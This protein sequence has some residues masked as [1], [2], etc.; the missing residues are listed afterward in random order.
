MIFRVL[1]LLGCG[2]H[3]KFVHE[4]QVDTINELQVDTIN[5]LQV[6]TKSE[7]SI[8][9]TRINVPVFK[10]GK[11][12][13]LFK[14]ELLAWKEV[15]DLVATKQ[16]I[17]VALLLPEDDSLALRAKLFDKY[18]VEDLKKDNGLDT[19][20]AFLD[21]HLG[22]D[23]LAD[24][25]V[26]YSQFEDY[27]QTSETTAD[28]IGK[29]E[30]LYNRLEKKGT[31]LPEEIKSYKLLRSA[32]LSQDER[33]LVL[34]GIDYTKKDTMFEQAKLSLKKFKGDG[35]GVSGISIDSSNVAIKVEPAFYS[36]GMQHNTTRTYT[37]PHE[38]DTAYYM[39]GSSRGW[40][41]SQ[42]SQQARGSA[43]GYPS[44]GQYF[45]GQRGSRPGRG[46][47]GFRPQPGRSDRSTWRGGSSGAGFQKSTNPTGDDGKPLRCACCDSIRHFLRDCPHSWENAKQSA[48]MVQAECYDQE[49][50][51]SEQFEAMSCGEPSQEYSAFHT[52]V[53]YTG[54]DVHECLQLHQESHASAIVD[55]ACT[56]NVCGSRWLA[57]Y[58]DTLDEDLKAQVSVVPSSKIFR[59]GIGSA[60]SSGEYELPVFLAGQSIML[61]TD[62]VES[63]VPL[64]LSKQCMKDLGFSLDL[65]NDSATVMGKVVPLNST[66]S[67]HY[68]L[69]LTR[70]GNDVSAF[71]VDLK[72]VHGGDL[73]K[74]LTHVHRQM[75]HPSEQKLVDLFKK[76]GAW[77]TEYK[78]VLDRIYEGCDTCKQFAR[79]PSNP[80]VALPRAGEFNQIVAMDLKQWHGFWILH[81]VDM[82]TRYTISVFVP[83]K[84]STSII[85]AIMCHWVAYFGVMEKVFTD[86]GGEFKNDEMREV[87]SVLNF[88]LSSS[89]ADSPFQ[90]GLCEKNHGVVDLILTKLSEDHP[91]VKKEVLLR[92]A[93]MSKN[94]LQMWSGYSSNQLVFGTNPRLPT[95]LCSSLPG[96][97][98]STVSEALARHLCVLHDAR[99][100]FI[101]SECDERL[102]RALR[103]RIR[104]SETVYQRGDKVFYK[105]EGRQQWLGPATV[106]FQD[107]KIVLLDHG[108]YFI[109][110][111]PNRLIHSKDTNP[112]AEK[113]VGSG[114]DDASIDCDVE[115]DAVRLSEDLGAPSPV[116]RSTSDDT[117][118]IIP[119]AG[120]NSASESISGPIQDT[121]PDQRVVQPEQVS[122]QPEEPSGQKSKTGMEADLDIRRSLRVFN[123]AHNADLLM[124]SCENDFHEAF[125]T[126]VP[127]RESNSPDALV[128]K[129]AE[130]DKLKHF[131]TYEV[132]EN[133]GQPCISTRFVLTKKNDAVR[134]R[135]VARGFE[136]DSLVQS[137][138]PTA[139]KSSIRMCVIIALHAGW[140]IE[141]TDIKSAFLQSRVLS[142]EV[143]VTPP[144]EADCPVGHVWK[145]KRC[146]YGLSDAAREFYISLKDELIQLGCRV[147][148]LD[149]SLFLKFRG[150]KL[151]GLLAAHIDDLFHAGDPSFQS[152]VMVKL[153]ERFKVGSR[154]T[155]D[156]IY[157]G[158]HM[159]QTEH[160][161]V[162]DQNHYLE[163]IPTV[164]VKGNRDRK[165][166][167][168]PQEQTQ[169]RSSVGALNWIVQGT[170]PDC[171]FEMLELS[172]KF[173]NGTV[174]DLVSAGKLVTRV[175]SYDCSI[176]F[177]KLHSMAGWRLVLFT[178][179]AFANLPDGVSSTQA[180]IIFVVDEHGRCCV[181]EW[182]SNKIQRVARSTLAAETYALQDGLEAVILTKTSL[183][184]II[185]GI[186]FPIFVKVDCKSLVEALQ[187]TSLVEEKLLRINIAAV[188]QLVSE[189]G[190]TVSWVPGDLQL[191]NGMT[192]KGAS[193]V[194]LLTA[195]Q[196]G[197]LD[198]AY[199]F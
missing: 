117:A 144:V 108:G 157:V 147:S 21:S 26:K 145:L 22:K 121:L 141:V 86:N 122:A 112:V 45:S 30:Q 52:A 58:L 137:D 77:E 196:S 84:D 31:T 9:S 16:G 128:A 46:S 96:L 19:V 70:S 162:V 177:P 175:K 92:W 7:S 6:D 65:V 165:S 37:S 149:S 192:K 39:G 1:F 164:T 2:M 101:Q 24:T 131:E 173:R 36:E 3:T 4:L 185:P 182:R 82:F 134:A 142:R 93:N 87:A 110:V 116:P 168:A 127:R 60:V 136:E 18:K 40:R 51:L 83:R 27:K 130:L 56:N 199:T 169:L 188:K 119:Q 74:S 94:S 109:K 146:L 72:S 163:S 158:F 66:S 179:A 129:Q 126:I 152:E 20:I 23:D 115:D 174:S 64:L 156:F 79:T 29:F 151:I 41:P 161:V 98:E 114:V 71:V 189:F 153:A 57:E 5:E 135:L 138:S 167:L 76:S 183:Q 89:D 55:T 111:S 67:G 132:V 113:S 78:G 118:E 102:R 155:L 123:K 191:A 170:R 160:Q 63:E 12:Y 181:V 125:V 176:T 75:G 90:N 143:F 120:S 43:P 59:F 178:D 42:G 180:Y 54:S 95:I 159:V 105:R 73:K 106:V 150:N 81:M 14:Q 35:R 100:A 8:M 61:K 28:F 103:N 13:D 193:G 33:T 69:P 85:N 124:T 195:L 104:T 48:S 50:Y 80:V 197:R 11:S 133:R 49:E 91:S 198:E 15:T 139:S 99:K 47:Y 38:N 68:C 62:V 34:S 88:S 172:T 184:E 186:D 194:S 44:R 107:R 32:K 140:T 154:A 187:S 190:I 25:L 53:L 166:E 171:A 10:Q 17:A 148:A 97:N